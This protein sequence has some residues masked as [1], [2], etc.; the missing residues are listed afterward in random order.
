[1]CL[2]YWYCEGL[3]KD[4]KVWLLLGCCSDVSLKYAETKSSKKPKCCFIEQ[5]L[6]RVETSETRSLWSIGTYVMLDAELQYLQWHW[7]SFSLLHY[8][9]SQ[10]TVTESRSCHKMS[11]LSMRQLSSET[12]RCAVAAKGFL[13]TSA[14]LCVLYLCSPSFFPDKDLGLLQLTLK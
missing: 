1:M 14:F 11:N 4:G 13:F 3:L 10:S 2:C 12:F 6:E 9:G 5:E 7:W 8:P